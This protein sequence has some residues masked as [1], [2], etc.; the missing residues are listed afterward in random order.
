MS[1][2]REAPDIAKD[3]V[4]G[5]RQPPL[6]RRIL[7]EPPPNGLRGEEIPLAARAFAA[8][9][10]WEPAPSDIAGSLSE[11]STSSRLGLRGVSPQGGTHERY[12]R[13]PKVIS[14]SCLQS[15]VGLRQG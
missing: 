3:P 10:I 13:L 2:H 12:P 5:R 4:L 14:D 8:V 1:S 15:L 9:D 11:A 7:V 6:D